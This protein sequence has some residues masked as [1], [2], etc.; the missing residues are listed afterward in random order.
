MISCPGVKRVAIVSFSYF[1]DLISGTEL[2]NR[3]NVISKQLKE[4][5]I[6]NGCSIRLLASQAS[7][8]LVL[9][10]RRSI[11]F[12]SQHKQR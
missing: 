4:M 9:L 11:A 3:N 1:E 2:W 7:T 8:Y 6:G 5:G 10:S 12:Q